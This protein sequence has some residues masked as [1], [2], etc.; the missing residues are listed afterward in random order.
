VTAA[1]EPA[2]KPSP[3][4]EQLTRVMLAADAIHD[5]TCVIRVHDGPRQCNE[6]KR[7]VGWTTLAALDH[8]IEDPRDAAGARSIFHDAVCYGG[9][10]CTPIGDHAKRT[11]SKPVAALRKHVA[12]LTA[13]QGTD[14]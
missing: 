6:W 4:P 11:Q 14:S 9:A 5:A 7:L 3:T 13:S 8:L 1:T 12:A 2:T 10:E